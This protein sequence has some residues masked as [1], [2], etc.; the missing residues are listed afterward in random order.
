MNGNL[1]SI[2]KR[3]RRAGQ[4]ILQRPADLVAHA[5]RIRTAALLPGAEPL[6]G[7]L[8]D[9]LSSC[10]PDPERLAPLL[11]DI[12]ARER[13]P[14]HVL[15][16]FT[17][18]A[19]SGQRLPRVNTLATRWSVLAMPSLDVPA[20]AQLC[21]TDDSRDL[22][23]RALPAMLAG[24]QAVEEEFLAHCEGARDTLAF[25]LA[26]RRLR[27]EGRALSPR[28]EAVADVLQHEARA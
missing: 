23:S 15:R 16:G 25:M 9:M 26:R 13:L 18:Q 19:D 1:L 10:D 14:A 28:W 11:D 7:A 22:A 21:S 2:R 8:A 5:M 12:G 20:H 27:Q 6:Q 24:D 4:R 3:F 17:Q